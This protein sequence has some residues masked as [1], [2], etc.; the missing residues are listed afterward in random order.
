MRAKKGK[1]PT[2]QACPARKH[3]KQIKAGAAL[4]LACVAALVD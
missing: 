3:P 2:W 1:S 4:I